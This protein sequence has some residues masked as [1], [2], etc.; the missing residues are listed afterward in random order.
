MKKGRRETWTILGAFLFF[1]VSLPLDHQC[2]NQTL[3]P[4]PAASERSDREVAKGQVGNQ[5]PFQDAFCLA[6]LWAQSLL[7]GSATAGLLP[8]I[9]VLS[10]RAQAESCRLPVPYFIQSASKRDPPAAFI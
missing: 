5:N 3:S 2:F 9:A 7:P 8:G 10:V 6:C 1:A 4:A